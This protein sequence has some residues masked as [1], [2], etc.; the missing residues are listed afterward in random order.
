M[1]E[2]AARLLRGRASRRGMG[3][4]GPALAIVLAPFI[5]VLAV[6]PAPVTPPERE[7]RAFLNGEGFPVCRARAPRMAFA[8]VLMNG[9]PILARLLGGTDAQIGLLSAAVILT[10]IPQYSS[11]QLLARFCPER[12]ACC[13]PKAGL[14]FNR[15]VVRAV[16]IVGLVGVLMVG[17]PGCSGAGELKLFA[18]SGADSVGRCL[19]RWPRWRPLPAL[20]VAQPGALRA[21]A[22][23]ARRARMVRRAARVR[24]LPDG[25]QGGGG[26]A[27]RLFPRPQA[28]SSPPSRRRRST[29]RR[30]GGRVSHGN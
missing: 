12:A 20:R 18:G 5:G 11:V 14:A 1:A 29:W 27:G 15:F 4:F 6:R 25:A 19:S 30:G 24:H 21:R 16:G 22:R 28:P 7:R 17:E 26:R 13:P 8:Q 10:L 23:L 9:G 2:S 3:R